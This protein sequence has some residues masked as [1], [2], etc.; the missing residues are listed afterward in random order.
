MP[1]RIALAVTMLLTASA[2]AAQQPAS[3]PA[4]KTI[5]ETS[6]LWRMRIVWETD[7]IQIK[8]GSIGHYVLKFDNK[9]WWRKHWTVETFTAVETPRVRLPDDTPADW[10]AADFDDSSWVR[11]RGPI[12][13]GG[14]KSDRNW[15]SS[16]NTWKMLMLRGRFEVADPSNAGGLTLSVVYKGGVVVYL[17]G[18]EIARRTMPVGKLDVHAHAEPYP[19]RAFVAEEGYLPGTY[20]CRGGKNA[21]VLNAR[22]RRLEGLKIPAAKLRKGVNVLAVGIHRAPADWRYYTTRVR[23]FAYGVTDDR[24]KARWSRMTL[25]AIRLAAGANAAVTGPTGRKSK[26]K[27]LLAWNHSILRKVQGTDYADP[28]ETLRP[29]RVAGPRNGACA[30][31][32]VLGMDGPIKGVKAVAS[33]LTGPGGK[34][35][36]ASAVEIRYARPDGRKSG[37]RVSLTPWFDSLTK[38]PPAV[39][40]PAVKGRG[41]I[42]PVWV[43]VRIPSGAAPGDYAGELT[44]TAEGADPLR[45]P[46]RARVLDWTLPDVNDY[47]V[48]MDII[49]SPESVAMGYDAELWSEKHWKLLDESFAVFKPLAV[50][51]LYITCVRRTHFGNEHAMVRWKR[52]A[53]GE[54]TPD[55]S[56]AERYLDTAVKH[57]GKIPGVIL[58]AWEPPESMGHAGSGPSRTHDREILITVVDAGTGELT[59]EKG[60]KWGTPGCEAFWSKLALGARAMLA[61]R[62]MEKSMLFGLLGDHRPTKL[63]MDTMTA[64]VP[65]TKWGLHS[66]NYCDSWMGHDMGMCIALWGIKCHPRDPSAG[67]G[68]GWRNKFWMGYYPREMSLMSPLVE[69]RVKAENHLGAIPWNLG[70]WPKAEG[71]RGIGRIGGDFWP[72]LRSKRGRTSTIA[73]RYPETYW[74]Q[75]CLNYGVPALFGRGPDG[76]APTVRSEGFRENAQEIEA[77]V[78]IEKALLDPARK[79]ALGDDLAHRCRAAL[80]TRIR[81][82]LHASGEGWL[83]YAAG[84]WAER[85]ELLY[86]LAGEVGRKTAP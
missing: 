79:A 31:Q 81:S 75:L 76:P 64:A 74:G 65:G 39:A 4:G 66:H 6:D 13:S 32:I 51:T 43:T 44:V 34:L 63:A 60:P 37:Y 50:K 22:I 20:D 57:L 62:G 42:Q 48:H 18:E 41:A 25:E 70:R 80:D 52:G 46:V 23:P 16:R 29:I 67:H 12:F 78:T 45:V 30:G 40:E 58:Y 85:T 17:N 61:K 1:L 55:F 56:I 26:P 38:S 24:N 21:D 53:D 49:Q 72:V 36:P 77:R 27:E 33:D 15:G 83:W 35:L 47:V 19:K 3:A 9:P 7:E 2:A 73:A 86:S 8:D 69:H 5:L 82:C 11:T 14:L 68:Y 10:P 59:K 28:F 54:L 84:G 71:I